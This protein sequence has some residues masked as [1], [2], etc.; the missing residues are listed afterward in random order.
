MH[1]PMPSFDPLQRAIYRYARGLDEPA[2]PEE[3][4]A[5]VDCADVVQHVHIPVW[6]VDA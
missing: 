1:D 4:Q 5:A 3:W 2:T 6:H